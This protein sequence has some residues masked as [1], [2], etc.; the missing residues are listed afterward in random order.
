MS[1][2]FNPCAP[3]CDSKCRT[4]YRL[5][6]DGKILWDADFYFDSNLTFNAFLSGLDGTVNHT[7]CDVDSLGNIYHT[8]NRTNFLRPDPTS[9]QPLMYTLRSYN[10]DGKLRWSWSE[11]PNGTILAGLRKG[12]TPLLKVRTSLNGTDPI[13]I[14]A[15]DW[16][17]NTSAASSPGGTTQY[18]DGLVNATALDSDGNQI[19]RVKLPGGAT[20]VAAGATRSLWSIRATNFVRAGIAY[21]WL[22]LRNSDGTIVSD[23]PA[24][25]SWTEHPGGFSPVRFES[26]VAMTMDTDDTI[27]AVLSKAIEPAFSSFRPPNYYAICKFSPESTSPSISTTSENFFA[28]R[29]EFRTCLKTLGV[30]TSVIVND[31]SVMVFSPLGMEK[32]TKS[33]L[34]QVEKHCFD[35]GLPLY[36]DAQGFGALGFGGNLIPPTIRN[37]DATRRQQWAA[38][39]ETLPPAYKDLLIQTNKFE[40]ARPLPD[41][42]TIWSQDRVCY[43]HKLIPDIRE[44]YN[45]CAELCCKT[46]FK[47]TDFPPSYDDPAGIFSWNVDAQFPVLNLTGWPGFCKTGS[48]CAW[49]SASQS[50]AGFSSAGMVLIQD[51]TGTGATLNVLISCCTAQVNGVGI[52]YYNVYNQCSYRCD[53]FSC[54]GGTFIRQPFDPPPVTIPPSGGVPGFPG[55]LNVVPEDCNVEP[56]GFTDCGGEADWISVDNGSGIEWVLDGAYT[57]T[58]G[59]VPLPPVTVPDEIGLHTSTGCV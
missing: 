43:K 59:C 33:S 52:I 19:W 48:R 2:K 22:V 47:V 13:I 31:D 42:G 39:D 45:P 16:T 32:F 38:T 14:L 23:M 1:F 51:Y 25:T 50:F 36:A 20:L 58:Y 24:E 18:A 40:D 5:D 35:P 4:L 12:P 57:C 21:R 34:E 28:Y 6:S 29:D 49:G 11:T 53:D 10:S 8:G 46:C 44:S 3:C 15:D 41:G 54:A 26:P 7:M 55:S 17:W 37:L 9:H 30:P 56:L 27:Y